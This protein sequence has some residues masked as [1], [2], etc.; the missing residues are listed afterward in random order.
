MIVEVRARLR[1]VPRR[2]GRIPV[3]RAGGRGPRPAASPTGDGFNLSLGILV[4]H[5]WFYVVYLFS[6]FRIWSLMR[7]QLLALPAARLGRH[8][9]APLVLPRGAR[10]AARCRPT[11][12]SARTP[13]CTRGAEHSDPDPRDPDGEPAVTE[14]TE[15]VP[16]PRPGRRLRRAVRAA[17]RPPR[18]RGGRVQ[19]DRA[20]HRH[21]RRA[22]RRRTRSASSSPAAR[23]RCTS[24]APRRSTP[25]VFDLGVPDARHLLRLPGHGAGARR[26]GRQHRPARVRGDGCRAH[27]RRRRAA[28]RAA[29]PSRTC[30]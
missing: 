26:R 2:I 30:G 12:Q 28:R 1:A 16:A 14:Q 27:G 18:A 23:R 29:R 4:A 17:D 10:R 6:C 11:S 24:R 15:T 3:V 5:G 7:W 22:S 19:R 25:G 21:R 13:S 20:A 8:R 9:P